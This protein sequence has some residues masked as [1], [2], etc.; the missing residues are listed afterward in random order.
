MM[1]G[2]YDFWCEECENTGVVD[3]EPCLW[4]REIEPDPYEGDVLEQV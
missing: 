4:C 2:P 1:T 3:G